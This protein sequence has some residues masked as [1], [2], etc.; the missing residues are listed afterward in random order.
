MLHPEIIQFIGE[1]KKLNGIGCIL[2]PQAARATFLTLLNQASVIIGD[3]PQPGRV[4]YYVICPKEPL[5]ATI[6]PALLI[7][8]EED[9]SNH[10]DWA[11]Q[12]RNR[13]SYFFN[14][15]NDGSP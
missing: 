8:T 1:L 2:A 12:V 14:V 11:E 5:P 15:R 10:P 3:K 7:A 4:T 6:P 13:A 9:Y